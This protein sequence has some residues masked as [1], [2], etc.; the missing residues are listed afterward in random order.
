M[1][2]LE[3]KKK[4]PP[5]LEVIEGGKGKEQPKEEVPERPLHEFQLGSDGDGSPDHGRYIS[6]LEEK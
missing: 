3:G 5:K 1:N 6:D 2:E 4:M